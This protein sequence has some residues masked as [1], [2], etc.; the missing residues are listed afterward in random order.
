[1]K[2]SLILIFVVLACVSLRAQV[3]HEPY[4]NPNRDATVE[5]MELSVFSQLPAYNTGYFSDDLDGWIS[6]TAYSA[7]GPFSIVRVF[8][9]NY[10]GGPI[11]ASENYTVL[12]YN[13]APNAGGVLMHTF[14]K[15]ATP[16]SLGINF[17]GTDRYYVDID[18]G[19]GVNL[20]NGWISVYRNSVSSPY[21]FSWM[22]DYNYG[23]TIQKNLG[24]GD[25]IQSQA[26][27]LICLGNAGVVPVSNW[28]LFIGIGLIMALVILRFR[29]IS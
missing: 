23:T 18:L 11:N 22:A 26:T 7:S 1:M 16:V 13:G 10:S 27:L 8:A 5:C 28:A 24:T 9:G 12:I 4:A 25:F 14:T 15:T 20:L 21:V 29:R 19:Q 17:N 6:F 3:T 2:K